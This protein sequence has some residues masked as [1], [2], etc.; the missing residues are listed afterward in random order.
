MRGGI[1]RRERK[2]FKADASAFFACPSEEHTEGL[3]FK[4]GNKI[5]AA[6]V[7]AL[8][9]AVLAATFVGC[10]KVKDLGKPVIETGDKQATVIIGEDSYLVK[11]DAVYV[12][13]LLLQL[14]EAG[15]ITYEFDETEYGAFIKKLGK[16]EGTADYSKWIGVY[17]DVDAADL[18]TP[19]YDVTVNGKTYHS[20]SLGVSSLPVRSGVTYL[21]YQN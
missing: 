2:V 11:T 13:D 6:V 19:G 16:L 7:V 9:I 1:V 21:F 20:A 17:V 12:H 3:M 4:K 14:K 15:K 5:F 8:L 10:G 18:I